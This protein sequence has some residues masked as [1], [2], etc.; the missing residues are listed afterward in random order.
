MT[1]HLLD[2]GDRNRAREEGFRWVTQER[3]TFDLRRHATRVT[4]SGRALLNRAK[5]AMMTFTHRASNLD[6]NDREQSMVHTASVQKPT[7]VSQ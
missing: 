7:E 1:R 3:D 4:P 2:I 6:A 5:N